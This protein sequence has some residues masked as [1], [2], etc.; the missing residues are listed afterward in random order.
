MNNTTELWKTKTIGA[1]F[2]EELH[3][4][5]LHGMSNLY[6]RQEDGSLSVTHDDDKKQK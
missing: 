3:I 4:D 6:K 1:V 2:Q 5:Q